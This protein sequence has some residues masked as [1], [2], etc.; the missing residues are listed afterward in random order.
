MLINFLKNRE[1][2]IRELLLFVVVLVDVSDI[3]AQ[4][5]L[6][7]QEETTGICTMDGI[8]DSSL[9]CCSGFTGIGYID[10]ESGNNIGIS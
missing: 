1:M 2:K 5:T 6:I 3:R 7:I 9:N 8:V 4:D 10:I